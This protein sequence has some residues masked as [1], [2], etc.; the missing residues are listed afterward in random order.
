[1]DKQKPTLQ[2]MEEAVAA[3][4]IEDEEY[5]GLSYENDNE[6]LNKIDTRWCL[7]GKF[8]TDSHIDYQAMQHKMVSLWRSG[9][10][11]YVKQLDSNRFIFQFYHEIDIKRVIDG[12][13]WTF[14]RFHLVMERLKDGD[15]P[16]TVEINK[17]DLWVQLHGMSTFFMSQRVA[18]D[19]GN[20]IGSYVDGDPNNFIGVWREY[21]RIRVSIPLDKPIKRRIKIKKSAKEWCWVNFQYEAIPAFCFIYGLIGHGER[22]CDRIFDSPADSIEEPYGAW[23]RA[24]PKRRNHTIGAKWLRTRGSSQGPIFGEGGISGK[25]MDKPTNGGQEKQNCGDLGDNMLEINKKDLSG[26]N[27]GQEIIKKDQIL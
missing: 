5:G 2:E 9:R 13:P 21:L 24:E 3:I 14:G 8:L 27:G 12:N 1:M 6:V 19:I 7:V 15:N 23:L 26:D 4:Q 10:G 20:Y 16:R 18:T 25:D 22:F 11:L 17:I